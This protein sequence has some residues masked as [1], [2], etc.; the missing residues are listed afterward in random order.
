M[1]LQAGAPPPGRSPMPVM[2][3]DCQSPPPRTLRHVLSQSQSSRTGYSIVS[4]LMMTDKWRAAD[5]GPSKLQRSHARRAASGSE[6]ELTSSVRAV[7]SVGRGADG[8]R[9]LSRDHEI[10]AG[11]L[12]EPNGLR[13]PVAISASASSRR[14]NAVAPR[15]GVPKMGGGGGGRAFCC[16]SAS[17]AKMPP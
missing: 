16:T 11:S 7:G 5:L 15:S 9:G 14:P 1:Q 4:N 6:T 3:N 12:L 13:L 10:G 17:F 8:S 2:S